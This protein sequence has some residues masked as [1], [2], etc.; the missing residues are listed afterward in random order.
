[1]FYSTFID[2]YIHPFIIYVLLGTLISYLLALLISRLPVCRDS[3]SRALIYSVPLVVPFLAFIIYKPFV[4]SG[5]FLS[6]APLGALNNWLCFGG[7]V[8]ATIFTP[9]FMLV[10]VAALVKAALSI[11]ASRRIFWK[12]GF[13]SP[14]DYPGLFSV[15]EELC[16][17]GEVS[18][19][20]II[21]TRDL[22]A[23][24]FTMGYRSPVIVFSEG[25]LNALDEQELETVVA[26]ELGHI[27]RADSLLTWLTV[28]LRDLMFFTPLAFWI[29]RD[30][31][32]EKEKAS[33]D[34]AIK[35]TGKP[36]AF[37]QALIKVW[38]LS[39][40]TLF[41]NLLLDN[42]MPHPNFVNNT[43]VLEHRVK[44]ILNDEHRVLNDSRLIYAVVFS[45]VALSI[46]L[47]YLFC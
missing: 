23:R 15:L 17:K 6:G 18:I 1:M 38:R 22:F 28:F 7:K 24:S 37:A 47:L 34:Y 26:H 5:C 3:R 33:D 16:G 20:R 8:L 44:R 29:F 32:A 11:F 30:L 10:A 4:I 31:T 21:V 39:P 46:A 45:V 43:G 27:V 36:L 9:L 14:Q 41:D 40:R 2:K 12:Y 25:L 13:A 35:L 42:F 19:P